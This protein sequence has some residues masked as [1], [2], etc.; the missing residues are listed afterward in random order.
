MI[1]FNARQGEQHIMQALAGRQINAYEY[2][3]RARDGKK[4][5][6]RISFAPVFDGGAEWTLAS[7]STAY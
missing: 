1:V 2:L 3:A 4:F 5:V 6:A 7:R